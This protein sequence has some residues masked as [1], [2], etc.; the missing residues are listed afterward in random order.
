M[1]VW[2]CGC[3]CACSRGRGCGCGRGCLFGAGVGVD[4]CERAGVGGR[5]AAGAW[6]LVWVC[7]G[8][9]VVVGAGLCACM[10]AWLW[11]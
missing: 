7:F 10:R 5:R 3:G 1:G 8:V 4:V 6:A 2:V 9:G 11:A